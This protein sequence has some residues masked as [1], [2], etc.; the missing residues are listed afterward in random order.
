[1]NERAA[2]LQS[3]LEAMEGR[4]L[5]QAKGAKVPVKTADGKT[6]YKFKAKRQK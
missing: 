5:A 3:V 1:M 6:H 4:K 2:K